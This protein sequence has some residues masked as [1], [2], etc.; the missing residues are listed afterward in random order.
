MAFELS[1]EFKDSVRKVWEQGSE[2]VYDLA[3]NEAWRT[4]AHGQ[5]YDDQMVTAKELGILVGESR[6]LGIEAFFE[7]YEAWTK[8][9]LGGEDDEE[10]DEDPDE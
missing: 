4:G 2:A 6:A 7:K 10:E 9:Q 5:D 3:Q 8:E 1:E